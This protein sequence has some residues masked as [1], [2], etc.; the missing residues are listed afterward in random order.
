MKDRRPRQ[1]KPRPFCKCCVVTILNFERVG[2]FLRHR[3]GQMNRENGWDYSFSGFVDYSLCFPESS[4]LWTIISFII[5]FGTVI[6]LIPQ[7]HLIAAQGSSFGLNSFTIFVTS[8]GQF[9]LVINILCLKG[10]DFIGAVQ[11]PLTATI[12]RFMTFVN[13]FILWAMYLPVVFLNLIFFDK[14]PRLVR[15]GEQIAKDEN[16]TR[17][18]TIIG[19]IIQSGVAIM[20]V[21]IVFIYGFGSNYMVT[22][23]RFWGTVSC[24]LVIAQY[25][26][27]MITT[28]K[29]RSNGSL[30]LMLL[31]LQAPGGLVNAMFMWIGQ[32]D[33]WTTWISTLAAAIQQI[34]LLGICLM[35]KWQKKNNRMNSPMMEHSESTQKMTDALMMI[36]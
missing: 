11:Y 23:G 19:A 32:G 1:T 35:F 30:S 12:S 29:L 9:I 36:D 8:F 10:A 13:A 2:N 4:V 16:F 28:C 26:P 22:M 15:N 31:S 14:S 34:I 7:I 6:S 3:S 33:D 24:F 17:S 5:F 27:Q 18:M 25:V 21:V 20:W